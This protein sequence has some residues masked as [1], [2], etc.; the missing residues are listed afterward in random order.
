[1]E[2]VDRAREELEGDAGEIEGLRDK[3]REAERDGEVWVE[4]PERLAEAEAEVE[5][6]DSRMQRARDEQTAFRRDAAHDAK[7]ETVDLVDSHIEVVREQMRTAERERDRLFV[8]ARLLERAE[9]TFRETHQPELLRRAERHLA[10]ITGGRYAR[11]LTGS[12]DDPNAL[13]LHANHL[14]HPTPVESPLSTGT[15]E[16]V[17][18]ALRLAIVDHLDEGKETLPLLLDEILVNW[19]PERRQRVLDLLVELSRS[20][21]IFLFTCH[22]H[23]AEEVARA[24]GRVIELPAP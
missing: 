4:V 7:D 22:P 5:E 23:L 12:G 8:L 9:A 14:P 24:G 16:Q 18:L 3:I 11:I 2:K 20:R 1:M 17:Y 21:Q 15:R 13:H 19:D 10:R 6:I